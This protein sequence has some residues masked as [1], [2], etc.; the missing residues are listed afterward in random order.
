MRV[1][2]CRSPSGGATRPRDLFRF[3][4]WISHDGFSHEVRISVSHWFLIRASHS[5]SYGFLKYRSRGCACG[6]AWLRACA[7]VRVC[8]CVR[9]S[10]RR[11]GEGGRERGGGERERE[12]E[13]DRERERERERACACVRACTRIRF[14]RFVAGASIV[15][16]RKCERASE[17]RVSGSSLNVL[18]STGE[19]LLTRTGEQ[20][21]MR[22][23]G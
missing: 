10:A 12:R 13:R 2:A 4:T 6:C 15:T 1:G 9:A 19:V 5:F 20:R 18:N 8:A 7:C 22:W 21:G 23:D 11:R 16:H 3:R 17:E 14:A